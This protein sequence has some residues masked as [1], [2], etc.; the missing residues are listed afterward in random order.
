MIKNGKRVE[1]PLGRG[2]IIGVDMPN[3]DCWG[4]IVE[5]D[6]NVYGYSKNAY[7]FFPKEVW[8]VDEKEKII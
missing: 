4:Y 5:L 3:H 7:R 8:K 2:E 1:T 6:E